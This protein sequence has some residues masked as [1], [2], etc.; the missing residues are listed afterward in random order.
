MKKAIITLILYIQI[1]HLI[2][3]QGQ[4]SLDIQRSMSHFDQTGKLTPLVVTLSSEDKIEKVKNVDLICIVDVSGSMDWSENKIELVK[5][6]LKYLVNLMNE[7]DNLALVTFDSTAR[8]INGLT[9]MTSEN[10]TIL[11]KK[12]DNLYADGGTN[13]YQGLLKALSLIT[14]DFSNGQRIVSMILLSDGQL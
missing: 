3:N 13:I 9:Q 8:I 10:K 6:S 2:S 4:V 12:I 11:L 7:E 14:N 5:D 1:L